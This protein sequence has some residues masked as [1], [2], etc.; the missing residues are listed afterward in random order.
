MDAN[1]RADGYPGG[2]VSDPELPGA[3]GRADGYPGGAVS[4]P[5]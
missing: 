1:G 5:S 2:A 3:N 4:D